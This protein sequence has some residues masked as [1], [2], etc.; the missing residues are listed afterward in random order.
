MI[1]SHKYLITLAFF[2]FNIFLGYVY[3]SPI[4]TLYTPPHWYGK[5]TPNLSQYVLQ[6]MYV[7]TRCAVPSL[8][9]LTVEERKDLAIPRCR[10][11]PPPK[12]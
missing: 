4:L 11:Q 10:V 12:N 7:C 6:Y 3:L 1:F 2:P 5:V 8:S 9:H